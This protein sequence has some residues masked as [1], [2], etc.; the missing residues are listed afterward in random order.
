MNTSRPEAVPFPPHTSRLLINN[1]DK[2]LSLRTAR[3]DAASNVLREM[4]EHF[5]NRP[6]VIRQLGVL[7]SLDAA[8]VELGIGEI[9]A[10]LESQALHLVMPPNGQ[11]FPIRAR[12]AMTV[13]R[14]M[15]IQNLEGVEFDSTASMPTLNTDTLLKFGLMPTDDNR[16][17][18]AVDVP[19]PFGPELSVEEIEKL[20]GDFAPLYQGVTSETTAK[21]HSR[22]HQTLVPLSEMEGCFLVL[23]NQ[24]LNLKLKKLRIFNHHIVGSVG[25]IGTV[26]ESHA[27]TIKHA[28]VELMRI[29]PAAATAS[30]TSTTGKSSA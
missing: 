8:M 28:D 12:A 2:I 11:P 27:R 19:F 16:F 4:A 18:Q 5:P 24:N 26:F 1:A 17:I 30:S 25:Y 15:A 29:L 21:P 14:Q 6:K 9:Y 10:P 3:E 23:D 13:D 7:F 22:Y 20:V